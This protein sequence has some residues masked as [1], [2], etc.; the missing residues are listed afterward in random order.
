MTVTNI[1][2]GTEDAYVGQ[3][4]RTSHTALVDI[5]A[6]VGQ[7]STNAYVVLTGSGMDLRAWRSL[8]YT[9]AVITNDVTWEVYGANASD[10][11]D[12]QAVQ[13]GAVGL[14]AVQQPC[15]ARAVGDEGE[16]V[17]LGA[18]GAVQLLGTDVQVG[19]SVAVGVV[20]EHLAELFERGGGGAVQA[21]AGGQRARRRARLS[22]K[23]A[24]TAQGR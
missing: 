9:L 12:E 22:P 17:G 4:L 5:V 2:V 13:A 8:A 24:A 16:R 14:V 6:P 3:T 18:D 11:S 15:V 21:G 20:V 23:A 7:L 10:Y 19:H 1:T